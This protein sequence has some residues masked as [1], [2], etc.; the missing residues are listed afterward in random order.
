MTTESFAEFLNKLKEIHEREVQGKG[1][2]EVFFKAGQNLFLFGA[3]LICLVPNNPLMVCFLHLIGIWLGYWG[4]EGVGKPQW[5]V[6]KKQQEFKALLRKTLDSLF[7]SGISQSYIIKV[8]AIRLRKQMPNPIAFLLKP[9]PESALWTKQ[10]CFRKILAYEFIFV[11][12][13][14]GH[15]RVRGNCWAI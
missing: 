5:S 1:T 14:S 2:R 9:S 8:R 12:V 3:A 11:F 7:L 10:Q 4:K 6:R 15:G 13:I